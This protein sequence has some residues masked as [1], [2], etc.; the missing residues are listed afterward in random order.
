MTKNKIKIA[1]EETR[2]FNF[3]SYYL[4]SLLFNKTLHS[5]LVTLFSKFASKTFIG[6]LILSNVIPLLTVYAYFSL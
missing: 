3:L 1:E 6:S 5:H 2:P 4:L